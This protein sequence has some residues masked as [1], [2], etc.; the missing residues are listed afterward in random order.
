MGYLFSGKVGGKKTFREI[1]K[2]RR[3]EEKCLQGIFSPAILAAST[4]MTSRIPVLSQI[5]FFTFITS[6]KMDLSHYQWNL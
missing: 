6:A 5:V 3:Q 2:Y 1:E 4:E